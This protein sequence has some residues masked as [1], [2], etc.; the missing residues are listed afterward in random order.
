AGRPFVQLDSAKGAN[1]LELF[2]IS[3]VHPVNG[4]DET[5]AT[6][7]WQAHETDG[8]IDV[9]MTAQST[10]WASKTFRFH[11]APERFTYDIVVEG[12]GELADVLYFGGHY[13]ESLRWSTGFFWSGQR[14]DQVFNPE[15]NIPET[16]HLPPTSG[17]KIDLTGVPIPNRGDWFF[18]PP[19]FCFA[20]QY[21]DGWL[22]FG[23]EAAPGANTY[24]EY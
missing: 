15:P 14:F 5:Y 17:S 4:R 13:V 8:R 21:D 1:L 20:G 19:P 6:G 7:L 18:T 10:A 22:G 3:S 12:Q 9:T 11:C 23:V 16:F 2:P 24:T